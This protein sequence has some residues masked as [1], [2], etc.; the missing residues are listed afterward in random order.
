MRG[1]DDGARR[2]PAAHLGMGLPTVRA[3]RPLMTRRPEQLIGPV[4]PQSVSDDT[5]NGT[6]FDRP[7][8]RLFSREEVRMAQG[9]PTRHRGQEPAGRRW[10][11]YATA[12]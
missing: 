9:L 5:R 6:A 11:S 10:G 1:A 3:D 7:W 12:R 4:V 8:Q 2:A